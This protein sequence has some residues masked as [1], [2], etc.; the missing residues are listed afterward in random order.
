MAKA[1][2][3]AMFIKQLGGAH[4]LKLNN[5]SMKKRKLMN[6]EAFEYHVFRGKVISP[7]NRSP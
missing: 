7:S 1:N 6:L 5:F 4:Y 2:C 3:E